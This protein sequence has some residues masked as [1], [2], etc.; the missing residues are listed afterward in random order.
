M[1]QNVNFQ[2]FLGKTR[3]ALARS[4]GFHLFRI[5]YWVMSNFSQASVLI[6]DVLRLVSFLSGS[7]LGVGPSTHHSF[8]HS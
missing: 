1:S 8:I 3:L 5:T 2:W 6:Y 7:A 4:P